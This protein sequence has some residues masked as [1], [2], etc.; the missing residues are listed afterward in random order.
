MTEVKIMEGNLQIA[1]FLKRNK[2][3]DPRDNIYHYYNEWQWLMPVVEKIIN[4]NS[5]ACDFSGLGFYSNYYGEQTY[6]FSMLTDDKRQVDGSSKISLIEACW[7]AVVEYC[8]HYNET[9]KLNES[10]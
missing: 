4:D 8:T 6:N 9:H 10:S 3:F 7:L 2:A 1:L 5:S